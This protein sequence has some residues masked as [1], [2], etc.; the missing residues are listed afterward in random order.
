M[1]MKIGRFALIA[2]VALA[3]TGV[4]VASELLPTPIP[5]AH[6]FRIEWQEGQ[7]KNGKPTLWGYIH[8]DY[9]SP[10]ANVKLLIEGLD[11]SGAPVTKEIGYVSGQVPPKNRAFFE[12]PRPAQGVSYRITLYS[13][14][15]IEVG[16]GRPFGRLP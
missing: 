5:Q 16:D 11:A 7:L 10:A 14:E 4:A 12:V 15:W 2:V 6:Y 1:P 9:G 3:L 13:F 8:N